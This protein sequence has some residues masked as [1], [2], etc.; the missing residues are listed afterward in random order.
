VRQF[1]ALDM[2]FFYKRRLHINF[3][4]MGHDQPYKDIREYNDGSGFLKEIYN[5]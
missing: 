2:V 5:G 3:P 1:D 4:Y